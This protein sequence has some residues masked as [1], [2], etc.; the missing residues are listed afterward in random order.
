MDL[1]GRQIKN[2]VKVAVSLANDEKRPLSLAFTRGD[3]GGGRE[4]GADYDS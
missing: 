1:N 3:E 4:R 2:V